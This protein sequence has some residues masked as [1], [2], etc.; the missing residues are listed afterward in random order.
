MSSKNFYQL[1]NSFKNSKS[2]DGLLVGNNSN[3]LSAGV[4]DVVIQAIDTTPFDEH[5]Y[6]KVAYV[7]A[8]GKTQ[9]DSIFV[10]SKNGDELSFQFRKF[11]SALVGNDKGSKTNIATLESILNHIS[12]G[13]ESLN[14]FTGCKLRI[15]LKLG[16][17]YSVHVTGNQGYAAYDT[18]SNEVIT[19][20][21]ATAKE[22]RTEADA[23]GFKRAYLRVNKMECTDAEHNINAINT[24]IAEAEK[25]TKKPGGTLSPLSRPSLGSAKTRV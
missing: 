9:N 14:I 24:A 6:F 20:E 8:E 2:V 4:H 15:E 1:L 18:E 12:K 19:D 23:K 21:Y 16:K 17:G 10:M 25:A 13:A 11:L 5:T 22:A 3:Y 7:D